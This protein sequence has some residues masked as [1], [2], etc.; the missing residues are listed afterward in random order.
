MCLLSCLLGCELCFVYFDT[1]HT[2][3]KTNQQN[4]TD[5]QGALESRLQNDRY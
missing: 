2:S 5:E 4:K 3:E 1:L